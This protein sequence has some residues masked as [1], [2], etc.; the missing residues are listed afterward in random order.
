MFTNGNA[1]QSQK[2][3]KILINNKFVECF[4]SNFLLSHIIYHILFV[5]IPIPYNIIFNLLTK[6]II[7]TLTKK[8]YN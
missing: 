5:S 2:L 3:S 8:I 6:N 1:F 7:D 4:K